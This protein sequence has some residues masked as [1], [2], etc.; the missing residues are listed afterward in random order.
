MLRALLWKEWRQLRLLRWGGAGMIL[1][2][3]PLLL[4]AAGAAERGW[5][6]FGGATTASSTTV[7]QDVL[8][9]VLLGLCLVGALCFSALG[10]VLASRAR[11]IEGVSGL[12]NFAMV[13]MWLGSG[14]FFSYERFP[15]WIHPVLEV[16][17]LTALNNALRGISLEGAGVTSVVPEVGLLVAW[18]FVCFGVAIR[19]FRWQ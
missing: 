19:I 4:A 6:P 10:L 14:V 15:E 8:P 13:P 16:I 11:T 1:I 17:P 12:M 9:L 18:A 2:L 7:I 5:L 3:P